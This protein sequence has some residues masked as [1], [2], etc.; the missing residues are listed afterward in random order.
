[1]GIVGDYV[2]GKTDI[3]ALKKKLDKLLVTSVHAPRKKH[4]R[5][6]I[7]ST[8]DDK[9]ETTASAAKASI[10]AISGQIDTAIKG[11]FRSKVETVLDNNSTKYDDI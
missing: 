5:R 3:K 7:V 10:T 2:T 4:N 8:Y 11:Q 1:M 9:I 6:S